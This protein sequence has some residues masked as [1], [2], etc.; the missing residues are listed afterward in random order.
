MS[1]SVTTPEQSRALADANDDW[2]RANTAANR[3]IDAMALIPHTEPLYRELK[4]EL[5]IAKADRAVAGDRIS[6]ISK[7]IIDARAAVGTLPQKAQ[8]AQKEVA[9]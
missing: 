8:K 9:R 1:E 2:S 7:Q 5:A 4:Q 3:A 6:A